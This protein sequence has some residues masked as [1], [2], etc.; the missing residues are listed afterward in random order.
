MGGVSIDVDAP[1]PFPSDI[2]IAEAADITPVVDLA[3]DTLGIPAEALVPYGHTKA[4]VS[5]PYLRSLEDRP[6]GH[7]VLVTAMSPTPAGEGKTTTSV[8]PGRRACAGSARRASSPCA[9][10]RWARCSA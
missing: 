5:L 10:R 8:G 2:E 4:K 3:R 1:T 9:S 7:L 6:D